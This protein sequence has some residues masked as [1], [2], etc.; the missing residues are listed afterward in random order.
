GFAGAGALG[1]GTG[2]GKGSSMV[3]PS[4]WWV[5]A[6][7]S[8]NHDAPVS[9]VAGGGSVESGD[10]SA[11]VMMAEALRKS[12]ASSS[13]SSRLRQSSSTSLAGYGA[14][15]P[16]ST[17]ASPHHARVG[18]GVVD[19]SGTSDGDESSSSLEGDGSGMA[20]PTPVFEKSALQPWHPL[21]A[22]TARSSP[23][24]DTPSPRRRGGDDLVLSDDGDTFSD[25]DDDDDEDE[26]EKGF[27]QARQGSVP[28]TAEAA[29][30]SSSGGGATAE[31]AEK[32]RK[33]AVALKEIISVGGHSP[34][35]RLASKG[36]AGTSLASHFQGGWS[37]SGQSGGPEAS[38]SAPAGAGAVR[39]KT[40]GLK[41][42]IR[43]TKLENVFKEMKEETNGG[44]GG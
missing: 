9:S 29:V 22:P 20:P 3:A 15:L 36:T 33:R 44:E 8:A 18:N 6:D 1:T 31:E 32:R 41:R 13:F 21:G 2:S 34:V 24:P 19:V 11:A 30:Q 35:R 26:E 10:H 14:A 40:F 5:L 39:A 38:S 16:G 42:E 37:D 27:H 4:S 43:G 7:V 12:S 28:A 17:T 25:D 23:V